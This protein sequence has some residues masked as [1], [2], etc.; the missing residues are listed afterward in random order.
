MAARKLSEFTLR[1]AL[2]TLAGSVATLNCNC[3]SRSRAAVMSAMFDV[4]ISCESCNKR[5]LAREISAESA[6]IV[7]ADSFAWEVSS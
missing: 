2:T 4:P 3:A 7:V 5:S 1:N 6:R